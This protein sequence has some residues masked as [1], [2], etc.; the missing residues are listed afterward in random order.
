MVA[1]WSLTQEVTGLN[2]LLQY[3]IFRHCISANS[4]TTFRETQ[5]L[6]TNLTPVSMFALGNGRRGKEGHCLF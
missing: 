6:E 4:V 3:N 2:N 5:M 1:S